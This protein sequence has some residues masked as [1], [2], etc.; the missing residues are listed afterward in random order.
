MMRT[1][2]GNMP[3]IATKPTAKLHAKVAP[4]LRLTMGCYMQVFHK[5][6]D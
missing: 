2:V 6:S 1:P 4:L 3:L 5:T